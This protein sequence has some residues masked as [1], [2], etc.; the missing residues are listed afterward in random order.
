MSSSRPRWN[1]LLYVGRKAQ[2]GVGARI[3][4]LHA[5]A[6]LCSAPKAIAPRYI[7]ALP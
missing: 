5:T 2:Y 4:A 6:S 1:G 3:R 7:E